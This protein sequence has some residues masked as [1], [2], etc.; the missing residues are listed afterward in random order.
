MT[1][2][3][4]LKAWLDAIEG[5]EK[6]VMTVG[7]GIINAIFLACGILSETGYLTILGGT[8]VAYITGKVAEDRFAQ[9]AANAPPVAQ[10]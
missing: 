8:I 2:P 4:Y 9:K 3:E 1:A 6:F 5:D 7:A 10:A